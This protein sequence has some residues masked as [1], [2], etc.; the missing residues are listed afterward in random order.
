MKTHS[1]FDSD[2][3]RKQA[4]EDLTAA[5]SAARRLLAQAVEHQ[6]LERTQLSQAAK[7]LSDLG[8]LQVMQAE[9]YWL[10]RVILKPTLWG[11]EALELWESSASTKPAKKN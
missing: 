6:I 5:G 1:W 10:E 7:L 8:F 2:E 4:V 3:E 9:D 11:E